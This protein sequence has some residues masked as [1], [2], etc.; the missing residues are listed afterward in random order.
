M[1]KY[2]FGKGNGLWYEMQGA[3]YFHC[4][5][6]PYQDEK[7][8][9]IWRSDGKEICSPCRL[10]RLHKFLNFIKNTLF[11]RPNML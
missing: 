9:G 11:F 8:I 1:E 10:S 5:T 2:I 6:V 7:P 3:Y 4:L